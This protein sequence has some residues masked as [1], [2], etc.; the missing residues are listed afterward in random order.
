MSLRKLKILGED[1]K[2]NEWMQSLIQKSSNIYMVGGIVR[3]AFLNKSSKDIDL[4]IEGMKVS[5]IMSTLKPFGK[6]LEEGKSFKV[7]IF[8]PKGFKGEPFDIAIPR[9]DIKVGSGHKGFESIE[10]KNILEDL[11]RR[12]FTINSMAFNINDNS[13]VD[14]FNGINDLKRRLLKATNDIAFTEDPLRILRGIQFAS[15]FEFDIEPNTLNMM[16]DNAADISE[17]AHE[18]ILDELQ[19]IVKKDGDTNIAFKL[20]NDSGL[21]QEIFG[22]E[23][24]GFDGLEQL[25][26]LSFFYVLGIAGGKIPSDF[27]NDFLKGDTKTFEALKRLDI[28]LDVE[29]L[30][31][32]PPSSLKLRLAVFNAIQK[33]PSIEFAKILPYSI[34]HIIG[35]MNNGIIPKSTKDLKISGNDI[36]EIFHVIGPSIGKALDFIRDKALLGRFDWTSRKASLKFVKEEIIN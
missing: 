19:K 35:L 34:E 18:R 32:A 11:E 2:S 14:P 8:K 23:L 29:A 4:V 22:Q 6:V 27:Y 15:R 9:K 12:D 25:D 16:R 10:A 20:I 36:Q 30:H 26:P 1:L 7:V 3:D 13:L 21:A 17:I 24:I 33:S 28:L 5:D 31:S